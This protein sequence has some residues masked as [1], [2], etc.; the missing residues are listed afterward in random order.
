MSSFASTNAMT[1]EHRKNLGIF[2]PRSDKTP[3]SA[4]EA[5]EKKKTKKKR[6]RKSTSNSGVPA[7]SAVSTV[8]PS[9]PTHHHADNNSTAGEARQHRQ[10]IS[11]PTQQPNG[12][13]VSEESSNTVTIVVASAAAHV[14]KGDGDV[15]SLVS[16][17]GQQPPPDPVENT[18]KLPGQQ[19]G[20]LPG[21]DSGNIG[22][23]IDDDQD[24]GVVIQR[25]SSATR[26]ET[27]KM[28][29]QKAVKKK[30]TGPP[31]QPVGFDRDESLP[32]EAAAAVDVVD[33]HLNSTNSSPGYGLHNGSVK[34]SKKH[35]TACKKSEGV[36][37][38]GA[39]ERDGHL[40]G[41]PYA[42][43]SQGITLV[44]F[45]YS[46]LFYCISIQSYGWV[47]CGLQL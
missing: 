5:R 15:V 28:A 34:P 16:T 26:G 42:L 37:G 45:A 47:P 46:N 41:I 27:V 35:K 38:D 40:E 24:V 9:T 12:V 13:A 3:G 43:P 33:I 30:K 10:H 14:G 11:T 32:P 21:I 7:E 2:P 23:D 18:T 6:R 29:A 8:F 19:Q 1:T 44:Y 17:S 4:E 20:T 36:W 22:M 25:E 31:Q 39:D